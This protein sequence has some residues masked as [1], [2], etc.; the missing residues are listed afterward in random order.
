MAPELQ[1]V[2]IG[3]D[4]YPTPSVESPL[5]VSGM[6]VTYGTQPAL[7]NVDWQCPNGGLVAIVGPNGAGKTTLLKASL[8][9]IPSIAGQVRF[10][11]QPL[12]AVRGK[13]GYVPQRSQVDWDFPATALDIVAL[14]LYGKI[15]WLR[16][17]RRRHRKQAAAYL[18]RV[19]LADL[20]DRQIGQLSGGQQQRVFLARALAQEADL[21]L[22]DEPFVGIDAATETTIFDILRELA[23]EGRTIVAVHHDLQTAPDYF[24]HVVMINRRLIAAGSMDA[25]FTDRN[26][27]RTYGG[28]LAAPELASVSVA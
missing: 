24:D 3:R 9:L 6:T 23:D 8:E 15:G 5:D 4:Y 18:D 28:R 20:A 17:V 25:T 27:Q 11:G 1:S 19:G 12:S 22:M 16:P 21:Y 13:V 7:W 10:W 2:E 26:L 14:G